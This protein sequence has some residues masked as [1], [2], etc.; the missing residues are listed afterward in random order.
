MG[1][2]GMGWGRLECNEYV[3]I[4]SLSHSLFLGVRNNKLYQKQKSG[5]HAHPNEMDYG[6][7]P[8]GSGPFPL[9]GNISGPTRKTVVERNAKKIGMPYLLFS[10]AIIKM[11]RVR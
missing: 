2:D 10:S 3:V 1:W 5:Y 8:C 9:M 6:N 11:A 4:L 7:P